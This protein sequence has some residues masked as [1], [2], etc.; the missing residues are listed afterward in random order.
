MS[1]RKAITSNEIYALENY[2]YP[3]HCPGKRCGM[4]IDATKHDYCPVCGEPVRLE[5]KLK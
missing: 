3:Y 5:K 4:W 2:E 1:D